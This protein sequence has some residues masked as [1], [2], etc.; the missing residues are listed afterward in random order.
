MVGPNDILNVD[1]VCDYFFLIVKFDSCA[2]NHSFLMCKYLIN[3]DAGSGKSQ[4]CSV[5]NRKLIYI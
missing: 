3:S 2:G 5:N 1:L 4:S